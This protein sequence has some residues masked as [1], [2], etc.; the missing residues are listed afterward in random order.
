MARFP[1]AVEL[2]RVLNQVRPESGE[3]CMRRSSV[4]LLA[5]LGSLAGCFSRLD[6]EPADDAPGAAGAAGEV[7]DGDEGAGVD[8]AEEDGGVEDAPQVLEVA[9]VLPDAGST[10]GGETVR[11]TGGPFD[12]SAA[13]FLCGEPASV[14]SVAADR[15]EFEAPALDRGV[16]DVE[17]ETDAGA[18]VLASGWTVWPDAT[19][20]TVAMA[21][22]AVQE[23]ANPD[24]WAVAPDDITR[25]DVALTSDP[26]ADLVDIYA[27]GLDRCVRTDGD[28]RLDAWADVAGVAA[29]DAVDVQTDTRWSIGWQADLGFYQEMLPATA[30]AAGQAPAWHFDGSADGPAFDLDGAPAAPA[31]F[32]VTTPDVHGVAPPVQRASAFDVRW[33]GAGQDYVGI[34]LWDLATDRRLRCAVQDDGVFRIPASLLSDF[35]ATWVELVVTRY[36]VADGV[37]PVTGG[38]VQAQVGYGLSGA[39]WMVP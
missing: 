2:A 10:A 6:V 12:D 29:G 34:D 18:G 38:T 36:A 8:D 7:E 17:V 11:I 9:A 23:T 4:F 33:S 1:R 26:R 37:A 35:G 32:R 5:T 21:S 20:E 16:C 14:L 22:W 3:V 19:G 39:V 30:Y 31:A 27:D 24:H 28:S 25:V 15:I 13:V